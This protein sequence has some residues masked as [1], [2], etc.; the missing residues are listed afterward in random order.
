[1]DYCIRFIKGFL[2]HLFRFKIMALIFLIKSF[3]V[4]EKYW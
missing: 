3:S 2:E 1:M 4:T